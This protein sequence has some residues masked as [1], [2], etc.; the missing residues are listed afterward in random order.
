MTGRTPPLHHHTLLSL[1]TKHKHS[2]PSPPH[3]HTVLRTSL[4]SHPFSFL[5]LRTVSYYKVIIII[6]ISY[7]STCPSYILSYI[8]LMW[9]TKVGKNK[10]IIFYLNTSKC[11]YYLY[12]LLIQSYISFMYFKHFTWTGGQ[13][14]R[15]ICV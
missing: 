4:S 15:S 13:T 8:S 1:H 10:I 2:L 5:A 6:I 14:N 9:I 11:I 7:Q 12:V 3:Y